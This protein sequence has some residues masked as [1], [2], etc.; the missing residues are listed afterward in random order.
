MEKI[1]ILQI[2]PD[3]RSGGVEN[4]IMNVYRNIDRNEIQFDF[5]EH[6]S[7]ESFFD[8]D[9][10]NLGGKIYRIPFR[11]DN[12]LSKYV[13][14]LSRFYKE[15]KEYQVVHCHW[16][17]MGFIHFLVAKFNGVKIR[18]GHSHNSTAG[19]GKKGAIKKLFIIPY[20]YVCNIRFACSNE[21]GKF[22]YGK[23]DFK[24]IPNGIDIDRF[25]YNS[26]KREEIRSKYG[27]GEHSL[28]IGNVGRLNVQKNQKFL[29]DVF[30]KVRRV[31]ENSFL[32]IMGSGELFDELND[33]IK[34]ED[35]SDYVIFAGVHPN[36]EDFYSAMDVFCL[37]SLFEGLPLTAVESQASGL[38]TVLSDNISRQVEV[39]KNVIYLSNKNS[40]TWVDYIISNTDTFEKVDRL[41]ANKD[42]LNSLYDTKVVANGIEEFYKTCYKKLVED[43]I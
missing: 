22:L 8:K 17:G 28:V 31:N 6:Y 32:L 23:K 25:Q 14:D 7:K 43:F 4:F 29:I 12:K 15:H 42:M 18:I 5:I 20:K 38:M 27:I 39:T 9:I 3:M 24:F 30:E 13:R 40:D 1:R 26:F 34:G 2:V 11:D 33:Y 10:E 35:L 21:S 37:P 36:V 16:N 19:V 41:S